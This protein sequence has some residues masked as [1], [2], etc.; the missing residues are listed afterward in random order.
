MKIRITW[1][2]GGKEV[3]IVGTF[4]NWEYMIKM[5]KKLINQVPVFEISMYVKEGIYHYYFVVDGKV[6][7]SP[8]Q[9]S[10]IHDNQK[11]VNYVEIDSYM[12]QKAEESRG[13]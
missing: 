1:N 6:R 9:P 12:I 8:D 7:F 10:A 5:H 13:T 3:F 11:I 4:T 2:Y